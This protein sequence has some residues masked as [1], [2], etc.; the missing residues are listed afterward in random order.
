MK[1]MA[2]HIHEHEGITFSNIDPF[3]IHSL[4]VHIPFCTDRCSYCDFFSVPF[5]NNSHICSLDYQISYVQAILLNFQN[6]SKLF[7]AGSFSTIYLGGGTPSVLD[8]QVLKKLIDRLEPHA[9]RYCEWTIEANPESLDKAL[10]DMLA[11]TKVN[12]ISLGIQTLSEEEWPILRRVGSIDD[13]IQAIEL[14]CEYPFEISVD[15]L[16]GIPHIPHKGDKR[17]KGKSYILQSLEYLVS[18]VSHISIYDLTLEKGTL[19]ESQVSSGEFAMLDEDELAEER[20]RIDIY[21][22][23][24][25]FHRYEVSNYAKLGHECRHNAAYWKMEPYLGVGCGGVSTIQYPACENSQELGTIIR[26]TE[27]KDINSYI[28]SPTEIPKDIE[29]IDRKTALFEFLMM[30]FRTSRGIDKKRITSLFGINLEECI[31][32]TLKRWNS[33]I[34]RSGDLIALK[35][36]NFDILN[37]FL[38]ECLEEL[39]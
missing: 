31:P 20:R 10:L 14:L 38:I 39:G 34:I 4:Y 11:C 1:P 9:D 35:P 12:R 27:T 22:E 32:F 25:G 2:L 33:E 6:W 8:K 30:G 19:I 5:A 16:L 26:I 3:E 28:Q 23:S 13:A 24:Q 21:L 7:R 18:R 17:H 29:I 36:Y 15:L 37:R